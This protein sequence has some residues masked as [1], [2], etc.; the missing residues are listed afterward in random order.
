MAIAGGGTRGLAGITGS[1]SARMGITGSN[2]ATMGITGMPMIQ[3][4]VIPAALPTILVSLRLAVAGLFASPGRTLVRIAVLAAAVALL[5][6]MLLFVGHSLRT[7]TGSAV[8][9][10][11]LD[12]QGPVENGVGSVRGTVTTGVTDPQGASAVEWTETDAAANTWIWNLLSVISATYFA[13]C[14]PP[15]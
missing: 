8:R 3:R 9:S 6:S 15:P 2:S 10:V 1:N 5:G 14:S 4:I 13:T 12:W 11:P 7:M